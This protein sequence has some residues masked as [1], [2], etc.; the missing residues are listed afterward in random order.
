MMS[1]FV[2]AADGYIDI[3]TNDVAIKVTP[4]SGEKEYDGTPLTKNEHDDFTVTGLPTGF[5][6]TAVADG[7]VTNVIPGEGEKA[8]NAIT[9]FHIFKGETDVTDRFTNI[10]TSATG[11]LEITA[12]PLTITVNG[13][14][15]N[16]KYS[17]EEQKATGYRAE[18]DNA[19]YNATNVSYDGTAEA[20][21]T[22]IG[23]TEMGLDISKFS[24]GD[25]NIAA[26]FVL[27]AD[28]YI[29]ITTNDVAIRNTTEHR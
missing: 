3:T 18:N 7:T 1:S 28:G 27:A 15:R 17:G 11:T 14:Q 16:V 25:T 21:R 10:D 2:L 20:A 4:S 9:E 13:T 6:W 19:L 22:E 8:E 29:D 5:T 24:Y 26:S 12:L 23:K